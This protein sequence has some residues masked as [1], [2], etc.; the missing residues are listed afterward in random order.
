M[1]GDGIQPLHRPVGAAGEGVQSDALLRKPCRQ[2]LPV[3]G[4][5]RQS[6]AEL[7]L[8]HQGGHVLPH[9]PQIGPGP[10]LHLRRLRHHRQGVLGVVK[11]GGGGIVDQ[12]DIFV[13]R[14][15]LSPR[16]QP[17][18]VRQQ[19]GGGRRRLSLQGGGQPPDL[20]RQQRPGIAEDL[21]RR[22]DGDPVQRVG[23][24]LGH[25]V[26]E[27]EGVHLLP[28]QLQPQGGGGTGGIN[29]D[30]PAP[31]RKL[32]GT[33]HLGAPLV[34]GGGQ[35][36][37]Q[38]LH[39]QLLSRHDI[40]R[41]AQQLVRGQ[42]KL[43]GGVGGGDDDIRP[44]VQ[45]RRQRPQ[46]LLLVLPGHGFHPPQGQVPAGQQH[47]PLPQGLQILPQPVGLRLLPGEQTKPPSAHRPQAVEQQRLMD[48]PHPV[49]GGGQPS[50]RHVRRQRAEGGKRL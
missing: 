5:H 16:R 43:H 44:P 27:G 21:R 38:I 18:R 49:E 24:P 8:F 29:V 19:G 48:M 15:G 17:V 40:D 20:L 25:R 42:G 47:H 22:R 34:T 23:A 36:I 4:V 46:P 7:P 41:M 32:A 31:H 39:R 35:R 12:G 37:R 10:L 14:G 3:H 33:L 26:E 13:Q 50:R 9:L 28:P 1:G 45:E 6:P 30:D 11:E 2:G